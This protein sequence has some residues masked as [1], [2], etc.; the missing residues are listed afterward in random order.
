MNNN[1]EKFKQEYNCIW[2]KPTE[3]NIPYYGEK[4]I[5]LEFIYPNFN[6]SVINNNEFASIK[7]L[8][9][10]EC[11]TILNKLRNDYSKLVVDIMGSHKHVLRDFLMMND[12][13]YR[14]VNI[15]REELDIL[16]ENK[17][18]TLTTLHVE[19]KRL[20]YNK[21]LLNKIINNI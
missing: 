10:N 16:K 21:D 12:M 5:I 20:E 13:H 19:N 17:R 2:I 11:I 9:F 18:M 7:E 15:S 1:I 3:Y 14:R 6:I 4:Y 8:N